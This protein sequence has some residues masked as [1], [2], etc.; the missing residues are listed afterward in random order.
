[1][2]LP[3]IPLALAALLALAACSLPP[4]TRNVVIEQGNPRLEE[5][6]AKLDGLNMDEVRVLL[7]PPQSRWNIDHEVW[8]YFS[9]YRDQRE[10]RRFSA[11]VHFDGDGN[12]AY[13]F[14]N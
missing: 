14:T 7:G 12:V 8:V 5:Q 1:M 3:A 13:V 11:E 9:S 10:E 6:I 4:V 2:R